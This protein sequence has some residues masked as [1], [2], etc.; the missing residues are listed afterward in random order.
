MGE[1]IKERRA[2]TRKAGKCQMCESK[3]PLKE[4][5]TVHNDLGNGTVHKRKNAA[6]KGAETASHYCA[7]CVERR[8]KQKQAWLN[9]RARRLA[10]G[11][12]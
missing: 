5:Y 8:V 7:E 10:K 4:Q 6:R 1:S 2:R 11:P 9:A 12:A 3:V